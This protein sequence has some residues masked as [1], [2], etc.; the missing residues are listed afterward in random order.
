MKLV[1]YVQHLLGIGHHRRAELLA[2][3]LVAEGFDTVIL[4]GGLAVAGEDWGGA[5]VVRLPAARADG[6]AFKQLVDAQDRPIDE[7]WRAARRDAL[8][9]AVAAE[10]PDIL[11]LESFPFAR[12]QF[13]FE[14]LPLLDWARDQAPRPLVVTSIRDIL[15]AK[16]EPKRVAEVLATLE[17]AVDR[18]LVHGDPAVIRLEA[19]FPAAAAIADK[20]HYTGFVA[21]PAPPPAT[22][23]RDGVIV[24]VGGGAVGAELLL[25]AAGA[26]ALSQ[27]RER[28]WRLITGPQMPAPQVA[29]IM[30]AALPGVTV[31]R[32]RADFRDLLGGAVLSISQA[33]YNTVLDLLQAG[34]RMVLVP[35]AAAGETEQTI[36]AEQLAATGRAVIVPEADLTAEL[37]AAAV[38]RALAAPA[39]AKLALASDGAAESA[40]L[41]RRWLAA[42]A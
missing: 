33:G 28:P 15:V 34:P 29:A 25:A 16:P 22:A 3:A 10:R 20:L 35:F 42:R 5:R 1:F 13:R 40:R 32:H 7:T 31:E 27:A 8:L 39:P 26:R 30:A 14:L 36:R 41:L 21:G 24:S 38:D 9:A 19:T 6:V 12:R 2:R 37:L 17:R 11:L 18:V 23:A 4:S